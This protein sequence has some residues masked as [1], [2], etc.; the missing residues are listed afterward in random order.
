[1]AIAVQQQAS[2]ICIRDCFTHNKHFQPGDPFPENWLASGY[3]PNK[4]FA[5]AAQAAAEI[6]KAR[7]ERTKYGHG[8]DPRSTE[9]LK[10]ALARF[11]KVDTN[12]DRKKIWLELTR[13]ENAE[14][15]DGKRGPGRPK[16]KDS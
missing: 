1:M 5:P 13:Y 12:W 6:A 16:D 3:K 10:E 14:A 8:D 2:F 15:K 9:Q 4:H 11:A 7:E